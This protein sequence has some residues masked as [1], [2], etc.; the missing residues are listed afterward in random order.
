VVVTVEVTVVVI[1]DITVVGIVTAVNTVVGTV[2]VVVVA[3]AGNTARETMSKRR[4][5]FEKIDI[6]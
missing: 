2:T 6:I 4:L 5:A 1:F 3:H